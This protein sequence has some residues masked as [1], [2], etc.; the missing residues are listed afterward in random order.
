MEAGFL[1]CPACGA[2]A[3][4]DAPKCQHCGTRLATVACPACFAMM[5]RGS[6]FCPH[7]GARAERAEAAKTKLSCPRC[8][9]GLTEV[10]L[11][12]TPLCE[13]GSCHGLW[14]DASAFEQICTD[15]ER[16][17]IV[18][19]T[20]SAAFVPGQRP[21]EAK[22]T[23][24]RCPACRTLMNR[25]NFAKCSGVIIDVCRQHG[26]WFDRDELQ[27]IVQFIHGGGLELSRSKE[28]AE[29]EEARRRL[30]AARA[31]QQRP[32]MDRRVYNYSLSTLDLAEIAGSVVDLF[33]H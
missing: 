2:S 1:S 25:V 21:F 9:G 17:S 12:E 30:E 31:G 16:H 8:S 15:R 4:T 32:E 23:Y 29:L 13:C 19:G 14:I 7:C 33:K 5:F 26:A 11:G 28:K 3:K 22:V 27:H 18:L 6:K 24:V 10:R 20:A